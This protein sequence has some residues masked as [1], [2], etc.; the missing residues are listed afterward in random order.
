MENL[1]D[2]CKILFRSITK[3]YCKDKCKR[4][5]FDFNCAGKERVVND[6]LGYLRV[7]LGKKLVN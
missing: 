1:T 5:R 4:R 7:H 6:G 3:S 2:Y